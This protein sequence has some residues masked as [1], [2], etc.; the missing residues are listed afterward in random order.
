M[1]FEYLPPFI[2][3]IL[4]FIY[5][6]VLILVYFEWRDNENQQF[7]TDFLHVNGAQNINQGG[8]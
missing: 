4:D 5:W 8:E 1:V 6:T 7:G 3:L 2:S